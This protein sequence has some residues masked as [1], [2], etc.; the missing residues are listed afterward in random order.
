MDFLFLFPLPLQVCRDRYY[1]G[2]K[3]PLYPTDIFTAMDDLSVL[4]LVF[5]DL[6]PHCLVEVRTETGKTRPPKPDYESSVLLKVDA[7]S[8][9]LSSCLP[10]SRG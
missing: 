4:Q 1:R 8:Y 10:S 5:S 3:D 6:A 7:V 2:N 9:L